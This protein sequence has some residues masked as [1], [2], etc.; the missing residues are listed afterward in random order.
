V[1]LIVAASSR[2][3]NP[4]VAV[5]TPPAVAAG[6]RP[7]QTPGL[8]AGQ[9]AVKKRI[10]LV[11]VVTALSDRRLREGHAVDI[12]WS[13]SATVNRFGLLAPQFRDVL[14]QLAFQLGDPLRGVVPVH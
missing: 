2:L 13:N 1:P 10:D 12:F 11:L 14:G 4:P 6:T 9:E 5:Q 7:A 8:A 3:P